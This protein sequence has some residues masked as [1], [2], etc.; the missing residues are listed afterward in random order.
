MLSGIRIGKK[1]KK[2][3]DITGANTVQEEINSE[4]G[5]SHSSASNTVRIVKNRSST[6]SSSNNN[7]HD[8]NN[9]SVAE[10]LKE[11]LASGVPFHNN[12][13]GNNSNDKKINNNNHAI[14]TAS[15]GSSYMDRV[16]GRSDSNRD[17]TNDAQ[18]VLV[19]YGDGSSSKKREEDMTVEELAAKERLA[20]SNSVSWNEDMR[21][22]LRLG[23]KRHLPGY[24]DDNNDNNTI[25]KRKYVDIIEKKK[26]AEQQRYRHRQIEQYRKQEKITSMCSWWIN[27]SS[28]DKNRLVAFGK[29]VALMIAP[30]QESLI[31]PDEKQYQYQFYLVPFK[32]APSMVDCGDDQ[33]IQEEMKLFRTSLENMY[34]KDGKGIIWCETVLPNKN[35]WQTKVDLVPVPFNK[36]QDAPIYF[37]SA[38][39]EQVEEFGTHT[40]LFST[41]NTKTLRTVIPKKFPYFYVDWGNIASSSNTGYAQIIESSN[42]P[43][44]FG[45]DTLAGILGL[46]SIRFSRK[47]KKYSREYEKNR[48]ADFSVKWNSFDWTKQIED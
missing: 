37:K 43:R 6:T 5:N 40:K 47:S 22:I 23:K 8:E 3:K 15:T 2:K 38:L 33:G 27:S 16:V 26:K 30:A 11:A 13:N 12:D 36:L 25:S 44:E 21:E 28:F 45:M 1:S 32:H 39:V 19:A 7:N 18:D 29:H 10:R 31:Y 17:T 9:L 24:D 48:V 4:K 35:F 14:T 42:F 41:S 20:G 34:A 46:N